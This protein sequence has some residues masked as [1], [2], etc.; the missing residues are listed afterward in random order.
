MLRAFSFVLICASAKRNFSQTGI[1][2]AMDTH[3]LL[4]QLTVEAVL[5]KWPKT[6]T[7]FRNRNTDCIGCLLQKFCSIQDVAETYEVPTQDLINDFEKCVEEN[8]P[9]Q[10]SI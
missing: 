9:T 2:G 10:R 1:F 5:N 6:F 4:T 3:N 7:V 8:Y